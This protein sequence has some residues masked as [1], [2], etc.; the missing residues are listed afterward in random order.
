MVRLYTANNQLNTL[1]REPD[2]DVLYRVSGVVAGPVTTAPVL[3]NTDPW[4]GQKKRSLVWYSTLVP[5]WVQACDTAMY[6]PDTARATIIP[7]TYTKPPLLASELLAEVVRS[8]VKSTLV[9]GVGTLLL[10]PGPSEPLEQ[11]PMQ[12]NNSKEAVP[13]PTCAIK[14]FL[15]IIKVYKRYWL[16]CCCT[17][18]LIFSLSLHCFYLC[19]LQA[20]ACSFLFSFNC[21]RRL[22]VRYGSYFDYKRKK[23]S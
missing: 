16:F 7:L 1:R 5:W 12:V 17:N 13:M 8:S 22:F 3:L 20:Q 2:N 23:T 14:S 18:K 9:G 15:S 19:R 10:P 21:N 11:P 6:S 4:L